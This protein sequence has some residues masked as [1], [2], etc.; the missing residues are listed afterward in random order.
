MLD[1]MLQNMLEIACYHTHSMLETMLESMLE[2]TCY[3]M[4]AADITDASQAS[5]LACLNT[6][7]QL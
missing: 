5:C 4:L 1:V 2:I 6:S 3:H 7:T